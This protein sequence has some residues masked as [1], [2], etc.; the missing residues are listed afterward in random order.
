MLILQMYRTE[1]ERFEVDILI[2]VNAAAISALELVRRKIDAMKP[3]D[4]QKLKLDN[5][6]GCNSPTLMGRAVKKLYGY[7]P[8]MCGRKTF[9]VS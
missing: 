7:V 2:E 5:N 4:A 8:A 1:D 6:Y 9:L 3:D